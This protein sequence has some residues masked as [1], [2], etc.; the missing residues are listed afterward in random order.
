MLKTEAISLFGGTIT[1][2]ADAVRVTYQAIDK[3]PDELPE[4][5]VDRVI[6]ACVR[7]GITVPAEALRT[8]SA[9][10]VA[11]AGEKRI[12]EAHE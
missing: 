5:L 8:D 12:G 6:A 10:A 4:R 2:L 3:W 1:A 11:E 7:S 9:R